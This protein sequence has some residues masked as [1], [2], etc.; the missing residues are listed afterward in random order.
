MESVCRR[1]PQTAT[2]STRT[3]TYTHARTHTDGQPRRPDLHVL[4]GIPVRV[5]DDDGVCRLEIEAQPSGSRGEQ[6]HE[7]LRV[8]PVELLQ[9]R[10]AVV[11]PR[12]AVEA[13][14]SEDEEERRRRRRKRRIR[15]SRS[16]K[17]V[18]GDSLS[19]SVSFLLCPYF[20]SLEL[21]FLSSFYLLIFFSFFYVF[22]PFRS[23][24]HTLSSTPRLP[25]F[26]SLSHSLNHAHSYL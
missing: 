7:I 16:R 14:V 20:F 25:L 8:W 22:F 10:P 26:S 15:S 21:Y 11:A 23:R 3:P 5:E 1:E 17:S 6:E 18:N 12:R 24:S 19:I 13:Q 4:M 9:Q 2:L